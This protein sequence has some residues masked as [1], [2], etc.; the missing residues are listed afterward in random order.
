MCV[1]KIKSY[2]KYVTVPN[3]MLLIT[4]FNLVLF[5]YAMYGRIDSWINYNC[6][7]KGEQQS[8]YKLLLE[9]YQYTFEFVIIM[10]L[11]WFIYTRFPRIGILVESIPL[12]LVGLVA[13]KI[14]V[15]ALF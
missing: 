6:C 10:F 4:V 11:G 7:P 9:H 3:V 5:T 13:F 8:P 12:M 2:L 15:D 14:C 1:K